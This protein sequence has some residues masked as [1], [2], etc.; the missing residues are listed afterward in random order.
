MEQKQPQSTQHLFSSFSSLSNTVLF[1]ATSMASIKDIK[2]TGYIFIIFNHVV[3]TALCLWG[4]GWKWKYLL[5]TGAQLFTVYQEKKRKKAREAEMK[6]KCRKQKEKTKCELPI[7]LFLS[8]SLSH[9]GPSS[10]RILL[11]HF[12]EE[13]ERGREEREKTFWCFS[14]LMFSFYLQRFHALDR[15]VVLRG[16]EALR[17]F[18]G[19]FVLRRLKSLSSGSSQVSR[20]LTSLHMSVI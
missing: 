13:E 17:V 2:A 14:Y 19:F 9:G 11:A 15:G 16:D 5:C 12:D 3:F 18:N 8:L 6:Q 7:V 1:F 4:C 20:P 10:P